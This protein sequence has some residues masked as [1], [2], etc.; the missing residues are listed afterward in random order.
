MDFLDFTFL[1]LQTTSEQPP[2]IV[3]II[4]L[5]VGI[6]VIVSQW[7]IFTKAGKP[8][9]AAIIPIY[10][11]IVL[12]EI[13]GRPTWWVILFFI[14]IAN[15]IAIIL[16]TH[17]LSESFGKGAGYTAGLLLLGF[18]F[19]PMLAFGDAKYKGPAVA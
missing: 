15:I 19:Y 12:L 11:V 7:V 3:N 2:L 14:P 5:I 17:N 1:A 8:G 10:N 18:I 9:W 13:V 4:Y 16:V 6:I